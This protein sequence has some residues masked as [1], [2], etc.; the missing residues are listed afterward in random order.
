MIRDLC[1]GDATSAVGIP[2]APSHRI[3]AA[4]AAAWKQNRYEHNKEIQSNLGKQTLI[5]K[6]WR[7]IRSW[8]CLWNSHVPLWGLV[9][10]SLTLPWGRMEAQ[11][12]RGWQSHI[13]LLPSVTALMGIHRCYTGQRKAPLLFP[14]WNCSKNI[15]RIIS[16]KK[17]EHEGYRILTKL[18]S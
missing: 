14:R 16:T 2:Q 12:P 1:G 10:L 8:T 17:M 9:L 3:I 11:S 13:R 4:S 6:C 18:V 15:F 5:C 7:S